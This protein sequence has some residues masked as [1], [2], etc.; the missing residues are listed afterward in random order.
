MMS[1]EIQMTFV[2]TKD[3]KGKETASYTIVSRVDSEILLQSE[4][5]EAEKGT[6]SLYRLICHLSQEVH[7]DEQ[8]GSALRFAQLNPFGKGFHG[9]LDDPRDS[10]K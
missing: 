3:G 8:G 2:I 6:T 10:S 7:L 4:T 5:K 9:F 1:R